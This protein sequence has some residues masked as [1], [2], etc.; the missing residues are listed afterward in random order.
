MDQE[1]I[2]APVY[3]RM[4]ASMLTKVAGMTE[5]AELSTVPAP[6]PTTPYGDPLWEVTADVALLAL[7]GGGGYKLCW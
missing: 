3:R 5:N 6:T 4:M 2:A 1:Y 7:S